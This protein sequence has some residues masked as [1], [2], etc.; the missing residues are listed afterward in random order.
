[1]FVWRGTP[2]ESRF[3]LPGRRAT[4]R[5]GPVLGDVRGG[6]AQI[7]WVG[8]ILNIYSYRKS[9]CFGGGQDVF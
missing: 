1:M 7:L 9:V 6:G 5:D 4:L 8:K 3:D 2:S